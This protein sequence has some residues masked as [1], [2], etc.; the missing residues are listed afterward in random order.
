MNTSVI[1]INNLSKAINGKKIIHEVNLEIRKGEIFGLLGPNGAGKTTIIKMM[2]GL[3]KIT[4]GDVMIHGKSVKENYLDTIGH[5]GAMIETPEF[6]PYMT[7][8]QNLVHYGEMYKNVKRDRIE[9][10]VKLVNLEDVIHQKVKVYSLGMRQRLGIAQALLHKPS[11]LILDEPTNG[12]DPIGNRE[13]R[14]HLQNLVKNEGISIIVSSH[15]LT[16]IELLCD[17]IGIVKSGKLVS[18]ESLEEKNQSFNQMFELEVEKSQQELTVG[19]LKQD[20]HIHC[21]LREKQILFTIQGIHISDILTTLLAKNIRIYE[22]KKVN[23]TLE[24]RFIA[25]MG[26][27]VIG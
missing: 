4:S 18:I 15:I 21:D 27:E 14:S 8:W 6:Y 20:L 17:R 23:S 2:V 19:I 11:I 7:G 12:L 9:Q 1:S 10:V 22:L 25:M 13:I 5:I 3:M 16:E 26:E 24:E